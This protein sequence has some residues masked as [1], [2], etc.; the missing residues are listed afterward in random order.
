MYWELAIAVILSIGMGIATRDA[1]LK[2]D[3]RRKQSKEMRNKDG[4]GIVSTANTVH[5]ICYLTGRRG[6]SRPDLRDL[7]CDSRSDI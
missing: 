1:Y 6:D 3:K 5:N 2:W 4:R 7:Y